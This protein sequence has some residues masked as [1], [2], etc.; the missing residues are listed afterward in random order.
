MYALMLTECYVPG[1][2]LNILHALSYII[3]TNSLDLGI[4]RIPILQIRNL[5]PG[6]V[7]YLRRRY[8]ASSA[9]K[10]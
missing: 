2:V 6:E 8:I 3:L 7:K 9:G 5:N 1:N 4:I 10:W